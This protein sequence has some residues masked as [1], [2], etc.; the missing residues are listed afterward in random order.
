MACIVATK[1]SAPT[2]QGNQRCARSA[3]TKARGMDGLTTDAAEAADTLTGLDWRDGQS[4]DE[5][6]DG[7]ATVVVP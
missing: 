6:P 3:P 4:R 5:S 7:V 2:S 1:A